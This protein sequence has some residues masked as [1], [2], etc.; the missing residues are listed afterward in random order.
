MPER[1]GEEFALFIRLCMK[2]EEKGEKGVAPLCSSSRAAWGFK[3]G[4]E[5]KKRAYWSY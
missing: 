1:K 5:T 4:D 3:G 2:E